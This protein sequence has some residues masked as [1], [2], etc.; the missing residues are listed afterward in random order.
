MDGELKMSCSLI[1][2][3]SASGSLLNLSTSGRFHS[4][5]SRGRLMGA[6]ASYRS[7][8]FG[9]AWIRPKLKS[10]FGWIESLLFPVD[11]VR[12]NGSW[13]GADSSQPMGVMDVKGLLMAFSL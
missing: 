8:Y 2:L 12:T 9:E 1:P 5:I 6:P 7:A 3:F 10:S 11:T 13:R 4:D